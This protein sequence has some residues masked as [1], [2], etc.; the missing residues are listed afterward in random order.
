MRTS[1]KVYVYVLT[2][3]KNIFYHFNKRGIYS[4]LLKRTLKQYGFIELKK[5]NLST[6]PTCPY[7]IF[8]I[9]PLPKKPMLFTMMILRTHIR[10]LKMV[11]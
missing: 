7:T 3:F 11:V 10:D 6:L 8:T 9:I 2:C 5:K 4:L 1:L